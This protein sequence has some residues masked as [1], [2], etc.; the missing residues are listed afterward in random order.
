MIKSFSD[1][2]AQAKAK[3]PKKVAA[4][5][6]QD[7]VV[8]EALSDASKERIAT[9]V[10]FGDRTAIEQAAQKAKVDIKGWDLFDIRDPAEASRAAVKAVSA[11]QADFLMKGLV[12]TST[13]L[14]AV[15]DKEVGLRT[16]RL[17][18][19]VAV[20]ESKDYDRLILVTDGGMNVKPDLIAKVD[21]INNAVEIAHKLGVDNPRVAV[22][23]AVEVFN[24]EMQ[25]TADAAHLSKMADRGQIKGC[26]VDGP[27]AMDLAVSAEAVAHKR[28]KSQVA[29]QAD[30]L[31][32]PE[33]ASGNML[34]KGLIYLGGAQA[35]G[36]IAGA[37]KPV[38]M[39]SR[40]DSKQQKI[41]SIAL[42][43]VSC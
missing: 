1:L 24:P 38:V 30:I 28:I 8:L 5:V 25:D 4:A 21:I 39:L 3:G 42:G 11:G 43:V 27:L 32:T 31:L 13:F 6:A 19:H 29:G 7:E 35:A 36:I 37:A 18:S 34:V 10:L 2:M 22:L 16:G 20:M 15:L 33:I 9:P 23:A 26:L 41:N 12:A 40:A 17:L 14:K